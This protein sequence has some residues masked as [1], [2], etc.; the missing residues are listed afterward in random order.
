[1]AD[2]AAKDFVIPARI[3]LRLKLTALAHLHPAV[4][5]VFLGQV[6]DA[7]PGFRRQG[8]DVIAEDGAL[9]AGRL[10]QPQQHSNGSGFA[11]AVPAQK[12]KD[13]AARHLQTQVIHGSLGAKVTRQPLRANHRWLTHRFLLWRVSIDRAFSGAPRAVPRAKNPSPSPRRSRHQS[14]APAAASLPPG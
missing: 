9:A 8:P 12:S 13:A 1:M 4:E 3:K 5:L 6:A 11:R 2:D 14:A 10:H 7:G